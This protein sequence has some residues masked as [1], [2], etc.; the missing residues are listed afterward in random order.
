[1][2]AT[3]AA[4]PRRPRLMDTIRDLGKP[5]VALMLGV[6]FSSGL[7][8]FLTQGT[9]SFWLR[10]AGVSLVAIGFLSWVGLAYSFKYLWS[11]LV[12]RTSVPGLARFGRRRS[13]LLL[14]QALIAAGLLAMALI[15][16]KAGLVA[17]AASAVFVAFTAATQDIAADA[18]RIEAATNEEEVR[19]YSGSFQFGYRIAVLVSDA[20]ILIFAKY[21]GWSLSYILM[22]V[23]MGVGVYSTLRTPEPDRADAVLA[24][25]KPLWNPMGLIDA[26]IGPLI[27]FFRTWGWPALL[28]LVMV[29][30]YR[31]P[32][33]MMGAMAGPFYH[34]LHINM[35]MVGSV[36]FIVGLT[37]TTLGIAAGAFLVTAVSYT[38]A[39]I[40]G[41]VLQG[42]A[43][44]SFGLLSVY[45]P[46][47]GLFSAIMCFDNFGNAVAGVALVTYMSSLTSLGYTATQYALLSSTYTIVGKWLKGFSG[48]MVTAIQHSGFSLLNAYAVYFV[49][50][51]LI[52]VPAIL[53]A[54]WLGAVKPHARDRAAEAAA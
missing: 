22:A 16:P 32:E 28:I 38:R 31:V 40:I 30:F 20:L 18:L 43:V 9:L 29:A 45:G 41:A 26:I 8:F 27:A 46:S 14:T 39:L 50:C 3:A 44:S 42:L 2:T 52:G 49:G 51:G 1:M 53:L 21:I 34:D 48:V 15:G 11:P 35:G 37:V 19:S 4:K 36:R 24:A 23:L 17:L 6:G 5:K 25:K 13:W 7:P 33:Y 47:L 10:E 12:D 54:M